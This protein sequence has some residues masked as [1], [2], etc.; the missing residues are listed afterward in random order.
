MFERKIG[1]LLL[2]PAAFRQRRIDTWTGRLQTL[3]RRGFA[4]LYRD[5]ADLG[6]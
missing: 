2:D 4:H 6:G 1:G 3:E 5:T